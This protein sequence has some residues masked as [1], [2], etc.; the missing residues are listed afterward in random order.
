[1]QPYGQRD[2]EKDRPGEIGG[3]I[4]SSPAGAKTLRALILEEN[5]AI[6]AALEHLML[7]EGY[8]VELLREGEPAKPGPALLL[9]EA[10]DRSG[11]YVFKV[12]EVSVALHEL[13][14]GELLEHSRNYTEGIR[15]F[16]P[17]PFGSKDVLRVVRAV[18]EFGR[19]EVPGE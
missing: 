2:P 12:E 14:G 19:R 16:I 18:D 5:P 6:G 8:L 9:A 10:R 3:R 13:S 17:I 15:A 11:L 1:M 4:F 7:R